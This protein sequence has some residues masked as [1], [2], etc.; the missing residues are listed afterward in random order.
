M[1]SY[2]T[3]DT[4]AQYDAPNK[5]NPNDIQ[6]QTR[7]SPHH[8]FVN[9]VWIDTVVQQPQNNQ[10]PSLTEIIHAMQVVQKS[11]N[12]QQVVTSQPKNDLFGGVFSWKDLITV[13]TFAGALIGQWLTVNE[14][15]TILE[16]KYQ[17][18]ATSQQDLNSSFKSFLD[19]NEKSL[20]QIN[21]QLTDLRQMVVVRLS[22]GQATSMPTNQNKR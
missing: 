10:Q 1:N 12:N 11:S 5:I 8:I 21:E 16:Q 20:A 4:G 3:H 2:I 9:G 17:N 22:N 6:I 19:K 7:P 15:L 13:L 18:L 14:R